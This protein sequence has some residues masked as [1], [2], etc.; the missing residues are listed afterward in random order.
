[1]RL[2]L[3]LFFFLITFLFIQI[4]YPFIAQASATV[5]DLIK[6]EETSAVYYLAEDGNRYA[7]P[8][9][10]IFYS[11]YDSFDDVKNISCH[12]LSLLSLKGLVPYQAGT[13]LVKIPSSPIVYFVDLNAVLRPFASEEDVAWLFGSSWRTMIDDLPETFFSHYTVGKAIEE[14]QIPAGIILQGS[15]ASLYRTEGSLTAVDLSNFVSGTAQGQRL[16]D[17]ALSLADFETRIEN[18]IALRIALEETEKAILTS[19]LKTIQVDEGEITSSQEV[20][21]SETVTTETTPESDTT[22]SQESITGDELIGEAQA[23]L[24]TVTGSIDDIENLMGVEMELE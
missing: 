1:M 14:K 3:Y 17:F 23:E 7:F 4:G 12:D 6:C 22:S 2:P 21:F 13:R 15:S 16:N 19:T 18:S 24:D 11:W 9:E 8:N 20:V 10:S 5:G